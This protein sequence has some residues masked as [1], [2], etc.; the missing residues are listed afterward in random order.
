MKRVIII[1][2]LFVASA[3]VSHAQDKCDTLKWKIIE[4][5]YADFDGNSFSK[6][7]NLDKAV[8]NIDTLPITY[9][10]IE[11][12]NI[13]NDTFA[14]NEEFSLLFW[15]DVYAD[16]GIVGGIG[17]KGI[18]Y[19]FI[20]DCFPNDTLNV[21]VGSKMELLSMVNSLSAIDVDFEDVNHWE[22]AIGVCKT[23][24]DGFYS[25]RVIYAGLDTSIFYIVRG[26]V[27]IQEIE[28]NQSIVSIYPN[29]AQTQFTVTNTENADIQLFNVL[30]QKVLQTRGTQE[31][32]VINTASLP[33]GMYVLKVVKDNFSTVHKVQ[34]R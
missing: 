5:Y 15:L 10:A 21:L 28:K 18:N 16:T 30:G 3:F 11:F 19:K 20:K 31:N 24:K 2:G 32:T 17:T 34:V 7:G 8:I 4:T 23:S 27:G 12:V 25:N 6:I 13:S 29:P 26:E 1:F 9:F 33:Q 22:F 14:V